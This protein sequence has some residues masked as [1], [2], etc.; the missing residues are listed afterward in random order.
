[1]RGARAGGSLGSWVVDGGKFS[2]QFSQC[3]GNKPTI[4]PTDASSIFHVTEPI[5]PPQ[6]LRS[7]RVLFERS[8]SCTVR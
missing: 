7:P 8:L 3:L 6:L 5:L 4:S 2:F 1:M